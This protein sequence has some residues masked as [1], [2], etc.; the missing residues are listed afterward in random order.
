[1]TGNIPLVIYKYISFVNNAIQ[2]KRQIYWKFFSCLEHVLKTALF[3]LDHGKRAIILLNLAMFILRNGLLWIHLHMFLF[4]H[5]Q[6]RTECSLEQFDCISVYYSVYL[7]FILIFYG[8]CI[9]KILK[10]CSIVFLEFLL[11]VQKIVYIQLGTDSWDI[12][13][14]LPLFLYTEQR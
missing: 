9:R 6:Q 3:F 12:F 5:S 14:N 11:L 1:M 8:I 7:L 4:L 2:H 10:H 13:E